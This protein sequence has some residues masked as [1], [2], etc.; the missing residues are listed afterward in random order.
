MNAVVSS[1]TLKSLEKQEWEAKKDDHNTLFFG[2]RFK[3]S[4]KLNVCDQTGVRGCHKEV[5]ILFSESTIK[6]HTWM[7]MQRF[8]NKLQTSDYTEDQE[9]YI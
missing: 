8:H 2:Y 9:D 4:C 3:I 1:A 5:G 7:E 6:R